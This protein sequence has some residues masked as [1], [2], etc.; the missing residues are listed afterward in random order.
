[1]SLH[2]CECGV[3]AHEIPCGEPAFEKI[4]TSDGERM[5]VCDN[6]AHGHRNRLPESSSPR[7][8]I[9]ATNIKR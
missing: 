2:T 9:G 4:P 5:W 3:E 6:C 1:M 7:L 8:K